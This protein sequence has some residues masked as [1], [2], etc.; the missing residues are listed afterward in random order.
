M[1]AVAI[2]DISGAEDVWRQVEGALRHLPLATSLHP[3]ESPLELFS[4]STTGTS[5]G[6]PSSHMASA[7][8]R[9]YAPPFA[10]GGPAM[11]R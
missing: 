6:T 8:Q 5:Q 11:T 3:G 1:S 10:P 4:A 2:L 7:A 9:A